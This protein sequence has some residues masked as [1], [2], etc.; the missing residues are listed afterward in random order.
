M[1]QTRYIS[2]VSKYTK[3]LLF[4]DLSGIKV[5]FQCIYLLTI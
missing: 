3:I 1:Q 5:H 4:S 2:L